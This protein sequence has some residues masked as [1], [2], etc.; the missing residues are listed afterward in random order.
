MSWTVSTRGNCGHPLGIC[1]GFQSRGL[2]QFEHT[3]C[4]TTPEHP[5]T[6]RSVPPRGIDN[7][8]TKYS[9]PRCRRLEVWATGASRCGS[10]PS[11]QGIFLGA[12]A[13]TGSQYNREGLNKTSQRALGGKVPM[14]TMSREWGKMTPPLEPNPTGDME[15]IVPA[16]KSRECVQNFSRR[17]FPVKLCIGG[18]DIHSAKRSGP[19]G[20]LYSESD[21]RQ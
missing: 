11:V 17:Q 12:G 10:P 6:G 8:T 3:E 9:E 14:A 4:S 20:E 1:W 19:C 13:G 16:H 2:P 21:Y 15:L 7:N 18:V 5:L